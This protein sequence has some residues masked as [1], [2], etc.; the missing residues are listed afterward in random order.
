LEYAGDPLPSGLPGFGGGTVDVLILPGFNRVVAPQ[1]FG[2]V[3]DAPTVTPPDSEPPPGS[4]PENP[5]NEVVA[6]APPPNPPNQARPNFCERCVPPNDEDLGNPIYYAALLQSG[7]ED[8]DG[9]TPGQVI[10]PAVA[11]FN[12]GQDG[13]RFTSPSTLKGDGDGYIWIVRPGLISMA[14]DDSSE[15]VKLV[16]GLITLTDDDGSD[17]KFGVGPDIVGDD[18]KHYTPQ[19]LE[20]CVGGSTETWKVL[21]YKPD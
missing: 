6:P 12:D 21:A 13:I 3:N 17:T 19:D 9:F 20:V 14:S 11:S 1:K 2:P 15:D 5:T 16:P 8:C 18:G 10:G 4:N 7:C